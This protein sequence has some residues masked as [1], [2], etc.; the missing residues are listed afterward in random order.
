MVAASTATGLV[1]AFMWR[2][3]HN[4]QKKLYDDFYAVKK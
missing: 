1:F 2:S 3:W 4:G